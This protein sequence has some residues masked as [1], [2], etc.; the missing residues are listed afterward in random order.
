M[1][2]PE[3]LA[4]LAR[5]DTRV[6]ARI[7]LGRSGDKVMVRT[8]EQP[9]AALVEEIKKLPDAGVFGAHVSRGGHVYISGLKRSEAAALGEPTAAEELA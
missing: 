4:A 9:K 7:I 5:P 6:F 2:K 8:M 1:K 3:I